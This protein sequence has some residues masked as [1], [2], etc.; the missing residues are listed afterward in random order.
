VKIDISAEAD[1]TKRVL[2]ETKKIPY[3]ETRSF[4]G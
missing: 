2:Y 3:G 1:F 4:N